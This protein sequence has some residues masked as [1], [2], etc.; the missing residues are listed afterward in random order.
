M[1]NRRS[2]YASNDR[3]LAYDRRAR[4]VCPSPTVAKSDSDSASLSIRVYD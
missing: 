4:D 3:L 2:R 1:K